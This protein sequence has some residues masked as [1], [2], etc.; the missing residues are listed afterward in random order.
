MFH[1][2]EA[3]NYPQRKQS[4]SRGT[5]KRAN[6][7]QTPWVTELT[8]TNGAK[9]LQLRADKQSSANQAASPHRHELNISHLRLD[10]SNS[11]TSSERSR[12]TNVPR[13]QATDQ[14]NYKWQR[15]YRS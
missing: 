1:N 15:D 13:I 5:N 10:K 11:K 4:G 2:C 9:C 6:E 12:S 14:S 3:T 8:P 7:S